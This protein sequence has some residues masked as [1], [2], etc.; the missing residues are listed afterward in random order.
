MTAGLRQFVKQYVYTRLFEWI[1]GLNMTMLGFLVLLYPTSL[2]S[3]A[4]RYMLGTFEA[5]H[6]GAL[7]LVFGTLRLAALIANGRTV[8]TKKYGPL[9]R[10]AGACTGGFVWVQLEIALL[11]LFTQ[12]GT[13]SPGLANWAALAVGEIV[14]AYHA[15]KDLGR[16]P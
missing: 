2:Q 12:S 10:I 4:F 8:W 3:S 15:G 1:M 14:A 11:I 16:S 6:I 7:L 9:I 13:P 5:A